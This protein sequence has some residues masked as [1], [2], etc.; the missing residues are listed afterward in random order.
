[1]AGSPMRMGKESTL[2]I[3]WSFA[4]TY[5][6]SKDISNGIRNSFQSNYELNPSVNPQNSS[7]AYSNFDLRH[8]FVVTL[9]GS[10]NWNA[11][12]TTSLT[13]FYSGQS[14]NPYS[15]IYTNAPFGNSSNAPAPYIPKDA[16]DIRL[17]DY[18]L[19]NGTT[20]TAAQQWADM[21]AF[22]SGDSYLKNH[23]GQYAER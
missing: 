11:Y 13:F 10:F 14:G 22:I 12:N 19:S 15:L 18:N 2:V 16:N 17:A 21:D 6:E 8:R 9:G 3:N 20:Y 7:L 5:G 1:K 23:R 4:Y